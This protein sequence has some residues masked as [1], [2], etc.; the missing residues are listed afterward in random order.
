MADE[1]V[2]HTVKLLQ[3]MRETNDRQHAETRAILN[4]LAVGVA[5]LSVDLKEFRKEAIG[6]RVKSGRRFNTLE[7]RVAALEEHTGL[8]KA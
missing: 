6:E 7:E 4:E 3:E 8:L 2:N 5:A 1:P